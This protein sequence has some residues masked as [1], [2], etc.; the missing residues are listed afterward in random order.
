M[1][2]KFDIPLSYNAIPGQQLASKIQQYADRHHDDFISDFEKTICAITGAKHAIALSSGTAAIHLGLKA[3]QVQQHDIVM[4][5]SF[6]YVASINPIVYLGAEPFF[7][8]SSPTDWNMD[9]NLLEEGVKVCISRNKKPKAILVVHTYGMPADMNSIMDIS[10]RYN[11]PV[12]EDAAEALGSRLGDVSVG[13]FGKVGV[14]SFNNN[15]LITTYGGGALVT[16]DQ[17]VAANINLWA[18]QSRDNLPFYEHREI[19]YNYKMGP[20][21]AAVGLSQI[22]ALDS[23]IKHRR[24]IFTLYKD[25][26]G[27]EMLWQSEGKNVFTNRWITAGRFGTNMDCRALQRKLAAAGIETRLLWKPMHLQPVFQGFQAQENGTG[28]GLFL[29]GLSFPSGDDMTP[30]KIDRI[31]SLLRG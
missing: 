8:D 12:L 15:K 20:I 30:E 1:K 2:S 23:K 22:E 16:D 17:S 7:I 11:I 28:E 19:G 26:F 31:Y 29:N 9:P 18:S 6:T 4:A 25:R 14:F 24:E 3:L 27:H 21:N 5:S 13:T 10:R